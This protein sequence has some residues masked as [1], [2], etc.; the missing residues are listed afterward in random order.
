MPDPKDEWFD[1]VDE[2]GRYLGLARRDEC[3]SN[4]SLIHQSV[5]VLVLDLGGR[6][7]L[8][9]RSPHKDI[10]PGKWDASVGG[11]LRP[12]ESA[13]QAALRE[14]REE[15]A[16]S[17]EAIQ[18]AYQYLWRSPIETELVHTFVT[19]CEGP[20]HL[21]AE[22]IDEGRFWTFAEVEAEL[23]RGTLTPNFEFEFRKF[24]AWQRGK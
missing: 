1:I 20:F 15:L 7:F 12:G 23:G 22:E 16:V 5:H 11:H 4:P 2:T 6:V 13:Y 19:V 9:K 10:Q 3:H 14:M 18:F 24:Q 21:N 17:P 8:Q